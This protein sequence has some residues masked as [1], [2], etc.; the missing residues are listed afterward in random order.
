[1]T[2]PPLIRFRAPERSDIPTFLVWFNDP[3][4]TDGLTTFPFLS[5]EAEEAWFD[6]MMKEPIDQRPLVIEALEGEDWRPI[7]TCGLF[8]I[9]WRYR[10]AELGISI[11]DKRFWNRGYGT[12]TMRQL[13]EHG[14]SR[15]NLNRI[16][17][18]VHADNPRAIR[19]YE[20]VG[21]IREGIQRQAVY[22]HGGYVDVWMMSVLR[23]EWPG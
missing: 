12:Q 8:G 3:E 7:G 9:N 6:N 2:Q 10:C 11:G 1:M 22:K 23:S 15:L 21:F 16:Y 5:T 4:V 14:F 13:V 19:C 17:L 20:K 18:R